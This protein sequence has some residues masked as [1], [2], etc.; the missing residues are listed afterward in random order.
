MRTVAVD[1]MGGDGAPGPEVQGALE[2]VR[3]R[4]ARVVLVGDEARVRRALGAS[5]DVEGLRVVHASEV[6]TMTDHPGQAARG[7]RDSSMRV[8]FE[9]ARR[10]EADAVVSAGNSGAFL[11]SGLFVMKRVA[12]VDRPG[13]ATSLPTEKE[14]CALLDMG[15]NVD[16]RPRHLAQFA[17]LGAAY[18]RLRHGRI[19]P[20]VG[21][22]SNGE[23]S[24]KGTE[25]T[26]ATHALLAEARS[27]DFTYLGYVEGK[28]VFT[29]MC[30]VVVTDGFTG[31]VLLKTAEGVGRFVLQLVKREVQRGTWSR[32]GA[33]LLRGAFRR[34]RRTVDYDEHGGAP[35][36][37]LDGVA[38]LCH[39]RSS[40]KAIKNGI[41]VAASLAGAGLPQAMREAILRHSNLWAGEAVQA[42]GG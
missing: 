3:Q 31:N 23:E 27:D 33:L 22:L 11:A 30:D 37:G 26:R 36:L 6:I 35:L 41:G 8:A 25:L 4:L 13:V 15:A 1:A 29:G 32:L 28:D 17:V 16:C 18:A 14:P 20:R 40:P 12:G 34:L 19:R 2:A 9:L 7:K 24:V 5:A 21:V 10:G 42:Q 38:V 39:G